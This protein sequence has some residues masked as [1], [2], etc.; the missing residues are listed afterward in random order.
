VAK[1]IQRCN[2]D[3]VCL[4][5]YKERHGAGRCAA[6]DAMPMVFV[7]KPIQ[8]DIL[9]VNI[10]WLRRY[11][12]AMSVIFASRPYRGTGWCVVQC[13]TGMQSRWCLFASPQR[14]IEPTKRDVMLSDIRG[15]SD[16][17]CLR[18]HA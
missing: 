18:A 10:T 14:G 16:T 1:A 13:D 17:V 4:R 6:K 9:L 5:A 12:D 11:G 3:G 2:V 15:Q 7:C 8:S